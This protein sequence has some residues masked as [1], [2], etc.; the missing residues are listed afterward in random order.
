M[1]F[2]AIFVFFGLLPSNM[3]VSPRVQIVMSGRQKR[4]NTK[5]IKAFEKIFEKK[6]FRN[7]NTPGHNNTAAQRIA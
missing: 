4:K 3:N 7:K 5:E 6:Y 2:Q 1:Y